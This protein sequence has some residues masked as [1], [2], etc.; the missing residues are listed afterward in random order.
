MTFFGLERSLQ[1]LFKSQIPSEIDMNSM[2]RKIKILFD[3]E[4]H[5]ICSSELVDILADIFFLFFS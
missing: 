3:A 1:F 4:I 5:E 2:N